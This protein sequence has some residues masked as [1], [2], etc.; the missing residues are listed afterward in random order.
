M[1]RGHIALN[2]FD[3]ERGRIDVEAGARLNDI[4]DN[5]PDN[6]CKRREGKEINHRLGGN[7]AD[8]LQIAHA[9]NAGRNC[10]EDDRC[11][12]HL[13]DFDEGIAERLQALA[14]F[15]I[16]VANCGSKDHGGKYLHVGPGKMA[17]AGRC[18]R[19][20]D[21]WNQHRFS[22]PDRIGVGAPPSP[23]LRSGRALLSSRSKCRANW[24]PVPS[25]EI[26]AVAHWNPPPCRNSALEA[27]QRSRLRKCFIREGI[28]QVA[29]RPCPLMFA[30][31]RLPV[32][33]VTLVCQFWNGMR[34]NCRISYTPIR[35]RGTSD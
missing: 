10:Q 18:D 7:S 27:R 32:A 33:L 29:L 23:M 3:I 4:R 6:E 34:A 11:D 21:S 16:E 25:S 8:L 14:G 26:G 24:T 17:L 28:D 19:A 13:D 20:G 9:G 30:A 35:A 1:S 15:R 12:N 31:D 22:L 2:G 5:Q